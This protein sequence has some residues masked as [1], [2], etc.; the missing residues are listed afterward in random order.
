MTAP[1]D[2][3]GPTPSRPALRRGERLA[4]DRAGMAAFLAA[5]R[6]CRVATVGPDGAPHVSPL[7]YAWDGTA[8]WLC[9]LVRSRRFAHLTADPRV[10]VV[11][12]AGAEYQELRGVEI[13]GHAEVV[14]SVPWDGEATGALAEPDRLFAE[15][16]PGHDQV[17]RA[18][19]HAWVRIVPQQVSSWDFRKGA[20]APS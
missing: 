10:S 14:G 13:R 20:R 7:W 1:E 18:G 5:E 4:M 9:S 6:T 16:Y 17:R 11:I 3:S 12:D 19:R 15:R 8:L 2:A